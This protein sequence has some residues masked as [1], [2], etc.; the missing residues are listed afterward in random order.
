M[1]ISLSNQRRRRSAAGVSSAAT[2]GQRTGHP[3]EP[4]VGHSVAKRRLARE[5]AVDAAMADAECARN[6]HHRS[7]CQAI[8]GQSLLGSVQNAVGGES[9]PSV[10]PQEHSFFRCRAWS[11][12]APDN[13]CPLRR[14]LEPPVRSQEGRRGRVQRQAPPVPRSAGHAGARRRAARYQ[15]LSPAP[16]QSRFAPPSR[17]S[18]PRPPAAI[19]PVTGYDRRCRR[20]TAARTGESRPGC[21]AR[22]FDQ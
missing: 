18:V 6:V 4:A 7:F 21:W 12:S 15:S 2:F 17:P 11:S 13:D 14:R 20:R 5:M 8:A 22:S 10:I 9:S 3:G 16:T 1:A 19:R